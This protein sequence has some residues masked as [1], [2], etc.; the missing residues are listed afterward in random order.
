MDLQP[1]MREKRKSKV[2]SLGFQKIAITNKLSKQKSVFI[3]SRTRILNLGLCI[4][5]FVYNKWV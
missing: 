5:L 3:W 4:Y 1:S 2:L